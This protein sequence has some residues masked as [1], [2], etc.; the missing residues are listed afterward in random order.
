MTAS[1]TLQSAMKK[2][3]KSLVFL[4]L[5]ISLVYPEI[6]MAQASQTIGEK[7]LVFSIEPTQKEEITKPKSIK[8]DELANND[9]LVIKLREYLDK[10]N[11]PLSVYADKIIKEP[12]WKRALAISWVE[13]NFGRKCA[14]NN[15][16]GIG[17]KPG[18][19]LWRK[20]STKLIWFEDLNRLLERPMYKERFTTF[21]DMCG[22][23]VQPCNKN[24]LL[25]AT[26]K[27]NELEA[28]EKEAD[29]KFAEISNEHATFA[30]A[31]IK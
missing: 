3:I 6:S 7:A 10:H 24:W 20:Y 5:I 31:S 15:C 30:L 16:S 22:V 29:E 11:S 27:Y 21:K 8:F 17:V 26:K 19:P 13:S 12:Q 1:T 23:Y 2:T 25:G 28:I 9:L 14:D 4:P 18:H